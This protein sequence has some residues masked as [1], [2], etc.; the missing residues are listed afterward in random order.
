MSNHDS[1]LYE[2]CEHCLIGGGECP[3]PADNGGHSLPCDECTDGSQV[4]EVHDDQCI[5]AGTSPDFHHQGVCDCLRVERIRAD[6]RE[7]TLDWRVGVEVRQILEGRIY[8]DLRAR[9]QGIPMEDRT[10]GGSEMILRSDVLA[11]FREE[12]P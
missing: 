5:G 9:V 12:K 1:L 10:W 11:L 3:D 4:K 8:A 7:K 6:E 2:C